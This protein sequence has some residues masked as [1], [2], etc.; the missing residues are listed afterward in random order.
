M[1][2]PE[3]DG[4]ARNAL[5]YEKVAA[6]AAEP[7]TRRAVPLFSHFKEEIILFIISKTMSI[8]NK[9]HGITEKFIITHIRSAECRRAKSGLGLPARCTQIMPPMRAEFGTRSN[10]ALQMARVPPAG[11]RSEAGG[12][13]VDSSH[14]V[15]VG[16]DG[17]SKDGKNWFG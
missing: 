13:T 9:H 11:R 2:G 4:N 10:A 3:M 15:L 16:K 17:P 8:V 1:A 7:S 14:A 6:T 5:T 12:G